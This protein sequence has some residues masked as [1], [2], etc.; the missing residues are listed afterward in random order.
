MPEENTATVVSAGSPLSMIFRGLGRNMILRGA[1]E[2]LIGIL[3]LAR[4]GA[5]LR[6]LTV[7][8]GILL[9]VDGVAMLLVALRSKDPIRNWT[10]ANAV[11]LV[12]LGVVAICA[13]FKMDML[14]MVVLGVWQIVSAVTDLLGGGWRKAWGLV[15]GLLSLAVGIV[16]VVLPFAA[17]SYI[18][19]IAGCLLIASGIITIFAGAG[20]RAAGTR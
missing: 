15:S 11:A 14:L 20:L 3:L 17:L 18:M 10:L 12:I 19:L 13:P 1:V 5:T 9:T 4:P 8:F 7:I 2:L 16:F 6:L